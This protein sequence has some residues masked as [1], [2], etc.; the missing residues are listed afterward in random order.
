MVFSQ[1]PVSDFTGPENSRFA[2]A[3]ITKT[4]KPIV[5]GTRNASTRKDATLAGF[6][7][8]SKSGESLIGATLSIENSTVGVATDGN[9]YYSIT[10]PKGMHTLNVRSLGMKSMD[11]RSSSTLMA[12]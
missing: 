3:E 4:E 9:G 2:E 11:K 10:L 7:K 8:N 5:I 6:I 1:T 12:A